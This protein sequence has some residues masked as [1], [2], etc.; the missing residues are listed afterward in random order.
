[1]TV[2]KKK[3]LQEPQEEIHQARPVPDTRV[4]IREWP[5]EA[6]SQDRRIKDEPTR[7]A[8]TPAVP[9]DL[10]HDATHRLARQ[11]SKTPGEACGRDVE[12]VH[13]PSGTKTRNNWV[14]TLF[15]EPPLD[16]VAPGDLTATENPPV[17]ENPPPQ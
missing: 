16:K 17:L 7:P 15:R 5:D 13:P 10:G 2:A 8:C 4:P 1:M 11:T 3:I 6:A 14:L 9:P 12:E